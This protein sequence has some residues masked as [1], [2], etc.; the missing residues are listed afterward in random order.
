MERG[1]LAA[2]S[3]ILLLCLGFLVAFLC[4]GTSATDNSFEG[5]PY[6][7]EEVPPQERPPME[8]LPF[9]EWPPS[10]NVGFSGVMYV[11][12]IV[13]YAGKEMTITPL[14]PTPLGFAYEVPGFGEVDPSSTY[15]HIVIGL[16]YSCM[17]MESL[18]MSVAI[19]EPEGVYLPA[20]VMGLN[21]SDGTHEYESERITIGTLSYLLGQVKN[22]G[23]YSARVSGRVTITGA[24]SD[25]YVYRASKE[26]RAT[27]EVDVSEVS[28]PVFVAQSV[29]VNVDY[30]A[31]ALAS[32]VDL[33]RS[34]GT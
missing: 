18:Y 32:I 28:E 7:P 33:A 34:L 22:P 27:I 23:T 6:S 13:E 14:R 2:V 25:G 19:T 8:G 12:V 10:E 9:P 21:S 1:A 29:T 26:F 16:C 15:V 5:E 24:G 3:M 20:R 30:S 31:G 4:V 11:K 17:G